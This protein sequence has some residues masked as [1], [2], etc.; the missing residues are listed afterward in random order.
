MLRFKLLVALLEGGLLP[1][2]ML[3][4]KGHRLCEGRGMVVLLR[5]RPIGRRP[6]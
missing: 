4:R 1:V 2:V 5:V 3:L 6:P